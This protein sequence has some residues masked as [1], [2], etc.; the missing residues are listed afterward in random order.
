PPDVDVF[1]YLPVVA[2]AEGYGPDWTPMADGKRPPDNMTLRLVKNDVTVKGRI[3][4]LQGKP[5]VGAKIHLL[6]LA[7]TVEENLA[8]FLKASRS[9]YLPE[10]QLTKVWI[11]PSLAGLPKSVTTDA[12]GQFQMPGAGNERILVLS[13][14]SPLIERITFR[15]LPR[16]A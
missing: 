11:D 13:V 8:P 3:L 4:D 5:V 16:S 12:E 9:E 10:G 1:A 14:E 7:A 2:V 6:R 15:V